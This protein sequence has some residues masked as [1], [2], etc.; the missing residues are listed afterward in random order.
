MSTSYPSIP[1]TLPLSS[2]FVDPLV[3]VAPTDLPRDLTHPPRPTAGSKNIFAFWYKGIT[4]LHQYLLRNVLAWHRRF[5][6]LGWTIY[7][8]DVVPGS[9]LHISNF[10][11]MSDPDTFPAAFRE[12][13]LGGAYVLQHTSDLIRFPLLLKYGGI[14]LDVGV[15]MFGDLNWLWE[16]HISNPASPYDFAGFVMG[17]PPKGITISNFSLTST[18]RN[19]LVDRAHRILLALWRNRTDTVG[20]HADPILEHVP[21]LQLPKET[22][23]NIGERFGLTN[24]YITDYAIHQQALGAAQRWADPA[25]GWDG[26]RYVAEKCWL[27]SQLDH[28]YRSEQFTA[29]N[30]ERAWQLLCGEM[31]SAAAVEGGKEEPEETAEQKL[32]R[33]LVADVVAHSWCWKLLH[34]LG[35]RL[36]GF[37]PLGLMWRLHP[38]SDG[39]PGT[40]AAWLRWAQFNLVQERRIQNLEIPLYEPSVRGPIEGVEV[41]HLGD[42]SNV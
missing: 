28:G 11:D 41:S 5:A 27:L 31:P 23:M 30:G 19:P 25:T 39:R 32:A 13:R 20:M 18:P 40:Y 16:T 38:G 1:G 7:V 26:P 22:N 21:L 17:P 4:H 8:I 14:C 35:N 9:P 42:L 29:W 37:N 3:E 24:G 10:L 36:T 34:G 15:L 33:R 6:S 12:E 2:D